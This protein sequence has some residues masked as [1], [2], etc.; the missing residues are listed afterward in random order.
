M[1]AGAWLQVAAEVAGRCSGV[2]GSSWSGAGLGVFSLAL[3]VFSCLSLHLIGFCL[4][5]GKVFCLV[6][7]IEILGPDLKQVCDRTSQ[8]AQWQGIDLPLQRRGLS[9]WVGKI[10]GRREWQSPPVFLSGD[11]LGQRCLVGRSPRGHQSRT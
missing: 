7:P 11:S 8:V 6:Q 10:P 2:C 1:T 3:Q 4:N 5:L 9:L